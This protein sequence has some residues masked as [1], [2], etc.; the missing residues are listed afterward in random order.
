MRNPAPTSGNA[1]RKVRAHEPDLSAQAVKTLHCLMSYL[2]L[3][4]ML[5]SGPS[6]AERAAI[7]LY[8]QASYEADVAALRDALS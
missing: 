1:S 5:P 8:C 6:R 4:R 2:H 7:R 3:R